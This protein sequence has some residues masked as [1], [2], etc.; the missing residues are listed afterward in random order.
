MA[1]KYRRHLLL[2]IS[3]FAASHNQGKVKGFS[4]QRVIVFFSSSHTKSWHLERSLCQTPVIWLSCGQSSQSWENVVEGGGEL[5]TLRL[6]D[7][8][9]IA[10]VFDHG[11]SAQFELYGL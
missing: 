7:S 1:L 3:F 2:S 10:Q 5:V 9:G 6:V 8:H 4:V 11:V